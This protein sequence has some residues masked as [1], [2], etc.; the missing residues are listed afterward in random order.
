MSLKL[1]GA[2]LSP[3]VRK[4]CVVLAEK[5]LSYEHDPMVPFGVSEEYKK[6]HPLGRIP[7]LEDGDR[8]IPDSSAIVVYLEGLQ[9]EPAIFPSDPYL[10]ARAVWLEEYADTALTS[11][12]GGYFQERVLAKAFFKR[13]SDE[14]RLKK[15]DAEEI[16]AV[17]GYLERT[18]GDEEYYLDGRFTI[19]DIAV[20]SPIVNFLVAGGKLDAGQWP[21]L[22]GYVER[23]HARPTFQTQLEAARKALASM[24]VEL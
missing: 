1:T 11:I 2:P 6:K 10:H 13:E 15:I 21:K 14:E 18:L 3:Y 12:C 16:P 22:A 9:P 17:F 19:A 5:N 20:A 23:V 8:V 7:L 4:V 24:G